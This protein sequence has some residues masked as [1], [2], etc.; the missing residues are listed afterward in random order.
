MISV[1]IVATAISSLAVIIVAIIETVNVRAKK[2]EEKKAC[3]REEELRLMLE[4]MNANCKL[5]TVTALALTGG[6]LN[7]NV[8]EAL[9]DSD[10]VRKKYA[11]FQNRLIADLMKG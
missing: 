6:K 5:S 10:K 2:K 11:D 3:Q 8:E 4:M 7:G 9:E 1:E